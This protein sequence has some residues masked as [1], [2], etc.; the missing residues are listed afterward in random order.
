MDG[1]TSPTNGW[2]LREGDQFT[3][4]LVVFAT[5]KPVTAATLLL[6]FSFLAEVTNSHFGEFEIAVTTDAKPALD[7]R[8]LPL[9]PDLVIAN[10]RVSILATH[11]NIPE[12]T[13]E[14]GAVISIATNCPASVVNLRSRAP[15]VGITGFRLRLFASSPDPAGQH[16]PAIGRAADGGFILTEFRV[17]AVPQQASNIALRRQVYGSHTASQGLPS[18]RMTDGFLSTYARPSPAVNREPAFYEVDLGRL[19]TLD[20]IVVRGRQDASEADQL[21]KYRVEVLKESGAMPRQTVWQGTIHPDDARLPAGGADVI[22]ASDGN[23]TF[24]GRRIRLYDQSG[25]SDQPQ[26]AELEVYPALMPRAQEWLVDGQVLRPEGSEVDVPAGTRQFGFRI[27]CGDAWVLP[28]TLIYHWRIPGWSDAWRETGTDGRVLLDPGP[29]PGSFELQVQAQHSDGVWDASGQPSRLRIA[30]PWWRNPRQ[31][32][33]VAGVMLIAGA[34][35]WWWTSSLLMKRRL[36]LAQQHVELHR[37]RLRI[38]QDMHDEMGARLTYIALLADRARDER[39][40]PASEHDQQLNTLATSALLAVD[41]LD[42]IVWSVNPQHDTVG[43]LADYLCEYT[44]NYLQAAAIECHLSIQVASPNRALAITARHAALMAVKEAVHNVVKHAGA[45]AL[46]LAFRDDRDRVFISVTDNGH[47]FSTPPAGQTHS[48]LDN[49]RQRLSEIGGQCEIG[50]GEN[51]RG[52]RVS[53]TIRINHNQ[54]RT[55]TVR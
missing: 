55:R 52:T 24:A 17:E 54:E 16:P 8:W 14:F 32:T 19:T 36:T 1:L 20:H 37:E 41:A 29:P 31:L 30:L 6:Q 40:A 49:M 27:L 48:G 47:G 13:E 23:G 21:G 26:I 2:A 34:A 3:H 18:S 45:T 25:R 38:A 43:D 22:H 53:L 35:V 42:A 39:E 28:S 12:G 9:I 51:N 11:A 44:P 15:F 5:D 7:G 10:C 46:W 4:Q 50:A 33:V